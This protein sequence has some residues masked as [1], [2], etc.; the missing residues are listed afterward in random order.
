M[1]SLGCCSCTVVPTEKQRGLELPKGQGGAR[2]LADLILRLRGHELQGAVFQT[3]QRKRQHR[4][5]HTQLLAGLT[6]Q[7]SVW[8]QTWPDPSVWMKDP[9][10]CTPISAT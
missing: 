9:H 4:R 6:A 1:P 7:R 8:W 5:E 10:T 2:I 3:L